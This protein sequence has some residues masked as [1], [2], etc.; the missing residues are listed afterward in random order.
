MQNKQAEE[1]V[2]SLIHSLLKGDITRL[3]SIHHQLLTEVLCNGKTFV[4]L[5]D[6]VNLNTARQKTI[7]ENAVRILDNQIQNTNEKLASY[8]KMEKELIELRHWKQ[9]LEA[10]IEKK[11]EKN[12]DPEL[13]K[14]ISQSL[15]QAE[16]STR[17]KQI[18]A[19]EKIKTIADLINYSRY[20]L[21]KIRNCGKGSITE[22]EN[23]FEKNG[24]W[25]D[26][27]F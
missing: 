25:W 15:Q 3:V 27:E 10:N 4:E 5:K 8:D 21:L 11:V 13:M 24:L 23:Y 17:L 12:I 6:V 7:F 26:M 22:I 9:L 19:N 14:K 1:A 16:F 2:S 18:F 20:E